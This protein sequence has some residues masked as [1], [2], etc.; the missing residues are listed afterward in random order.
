MIPML[1]EQYLGIEACFET[2]NKYLLIHSVANHY[3][4]RRKS[5]KEYERLTK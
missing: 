1:A 4:M 2:Y 3:Q 5:A